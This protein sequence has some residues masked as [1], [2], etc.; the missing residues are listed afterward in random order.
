MVPVEDDDGSNERGD[1]ADE[2]DEGPQ[3]NYQRMVPGQLSDEEISNS[4]S[5]ERMV[6]GQTSETSERVYSRSDLQNSVRLRARWNET[7]VAANQR[8][9]RAAHPA[10]ARDWPTRSHPEGIRAAPPDYHGTRAQ[11][12]SSVAPATLLQS[13]LAPDA[14]HPVFHHL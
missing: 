2:A 13:S 4:N 6:T 1:G 5:D 14:I 9:S 10:L 8:L 7:S 12:S 11:S 3:P